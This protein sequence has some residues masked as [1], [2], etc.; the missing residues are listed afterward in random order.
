[1]NFNYKQGQDGTTK[2]GGWNLGS[3]E[4]STK[5]DR[6][7]Q[8][9]TQ[10]QQPDPTHR[11]HNDRQQQEQ[12]YQQQPQ[13]V[14]PSVPDPPPPSKSAE[15]HLGQKDDT[16]KPVLNP[17]LVIPFEPQRDAP[18]PPPPPSQTTQTPPKP[19]MENR[20]KK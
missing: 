13:T 10:T 11:L 18:P 19:P 17:D 15:W 12:S 16:P 3:M 4:Y 9:P 1:M 20:D 5:D 2:L 7:V 8:Q 6:P 14:P